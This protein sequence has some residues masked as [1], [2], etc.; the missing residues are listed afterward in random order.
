LAA[1]LN[2][3]V[4]AKEV[5]AGLAAMKNGRAADIYG[6]TADLLKAA[7]EVLSPV[8]TMVFNRLFRAGVFPED[9]NVG[10]L[11]PIFKKGDVDDPGNYR[12][13]TIGPILG[14]LYARVVNRRMTEWA[15]RCRYRAVGQAGFRPKQST[16]DQLF[17]LNT[18]TEDAKSRGQ[19]L[20]ACF[21]D[22]RKA[23][24]SV[25]RA[26]LWECLAE[27][28]VHSEMLA[29]VRAMYA[30]VRCTIKSKE[31]LTSTF[32]SAMGV[33]QGCSLSPL[34]F[35]LYIDSL[36]AE[37]AALPVAHP[38]IL[39]QVVPALLFADDVVLLAHSVHAL[40]ALL[41]GLADF[42]DRKR[43]E[44]N[45][46]K[47]KV[48]VL[49]VGRA[50]ARVKSVTVHYKKA[51]VEVVSEY[52][53][54]G[55]TMVHCPSGLPWN[56]GALHDSARRAMF[57]MQQ[58]L[59]RAGIQSAATKAHLFDV[60][61]TPILTY[62][63]AVWGP[64]LA[65]SRRD[66]DEGEVMRRGFLKHILG[67]NRAAPTSAVL[68][69]FGRFPLR[70]HR[71]QAA[72]KL[73][74]HAVTAPD[75]GLVS[76]A[77]RQQDEQRQTNGDR[78]NWLAAVESDLADVGG[79]VAMAA[80][81]CTRDLDPAHIMTVTKIHYHNR[82]CFSPAVKTVA[83]SRLKVGYKCQPY[84]RVLQFS[85][86]ECR[87]LAQFRTGAHCLASETGRHGVEGSKL[88]RCCDA[89][90]V[91]DPQHLVF[92]CGLYA[93]A[94]HRFAGLFL[95]YGTLRA[96]LNSE[97]CVEVAA[98]LCCCLDKRQEYLAARH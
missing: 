10:L 62:A 43:L 49:V 44:V 19:P 81:K 30:N 72:I 14:K 98:F 91:E 97:H 67:V 28:A 4:S 61:V 37:L 42:C 20:Y 82:L 69:E 35:G 87:V 84:L 38:K 89:G 22:F 39:L 3:E 55:L 59:Q 1:A 18:I 24:D 51:M 17:V 11:V 79:P 33:K 57:A 77:V 93:G 48:M 50:R 52:K 36:F 80:F 16:V 25:P 63:A 21:V 23:F 66:S 31:G 2:Q 8:I 95:Q 27:L 94:R 13:I 88:C 9:W 32:G 7:I 47:T 54:L 40:Q 58:R 26:L 83:Y 92:S 56:L 60:L 34:L 29:A 64:L 86:R 46:G 85:S 68:G 15:E 45:L 75:T 76:L 74:R 65:P 71:V 6:M 5:Q 12:L 70:N 78:R 96:F 90:V 73:V 53:Y 41:N